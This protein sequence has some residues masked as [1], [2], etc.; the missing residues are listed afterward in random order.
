MDAIALLSMSDGTA[1]S[2]YLITTSR[3]L[4]NPRW[5]VTGNWI[6]FIQKSQFNSLFHTVAVPEKDSKH[7]WRTY[8][9]NFNYSRPPTQPDW[10]L[11]NHKLTEYYPIRPRRSETQ[12]TREPTDHCFWTGVFDTKLN[13][14]RS[15]LITTHCCPSFSHWVPWKIIRRLSLIEYRLITHFIIVT[16]PSPPCSWWDLET[17][18]MALQR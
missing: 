18:V 15:A 5:R 4:W 12:K 2:L 8:N 7:H 14:R 17:H 6:S 13:R 3:S 10:L 1:L 11:L 9:N 16:L